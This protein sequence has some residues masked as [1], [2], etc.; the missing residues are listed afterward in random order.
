ML[1]GI[2]NA[3]KAGVEY[4][5][6]QLVCGTTLWPSGE[7][8]DPSSF[9]MNIDLNSYTSTLTNAM[10]SIKPGSKS[11][12]YLFFTTILYHLT[13]YSKERRPNST[14]HSK[15]SDECLPTTN[16]LG[17]SFWFAMSSVHHYPT[18]RWPS[19]YIFELLHCCLLIWL[20]WHTSIVEA[21]LVRCCQ[22]PNTFGIKILWCNDFCF[23]Q[24]YNYIYASIIFST[25]SLFEA[26]Y[27]VFWGTPC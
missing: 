25:Y 18:Y 20:G 12:L 7:F 11:S 2:S 8:V 21:S 27:A 19:K 15:L 24:K 5:E 22:T 3:L 16:P 13:P 4:T 23:P 17:S 1:F 10:C 9:S 26:R 14:E 6:A